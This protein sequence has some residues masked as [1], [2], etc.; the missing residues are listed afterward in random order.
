MYQLEI[1]HIHLP[2]PL[3]AFKT[4][5]LG[6]ANSLYQ[7]VAYYESNQID[8]PHHGF[9]NFLAA[10]NTFLP[11]HSDQALA[12]LEAEMRRQKQVL[13]CTLSY[14]LK[15]Q[16]EP[17]RSAHPDFIQFPV[18]HFFNP[19]VQIHFAAD[20]IIIN[21]PQDNCLKIYQA[22]LEYQESKTL[23]NRNLTIEQRISK[24][25]YIN[26]VNN[27]KQRIIEG[28]VYEINYCQEFY[29]SAP[30]FDPVSAFLGLNELSPMPFAGFY[31]VHDKYVMC[32]SPERFL[33]KSQNMLIA[34]PIKGTIR[35]GKTTPED[36]FLKNELATNE[37]EIAENMMIMDLVRN[38]LARCSVTGSVVVE[39]MFAIYSFK[40]VH[41]MITTIRSQVSNQTSLTEILKSTFPMG[42]MTG[43]PKIAAMRLIEQYEAFARGLY[44]GSLGYI[45]P[46]GDFDF[47]VVIRSMQYNAST[48][49]LSFAVGSAI[50][51]DSDPEQ[52][53]QECLLKAAA[54]L[55]VLQPKL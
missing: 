44:S 54:L 55:Q 11:I 34:Q 19:E 43:A 52:E 18:I 31:K 35:R 40:Q 21:S 22:I 1:L 53:Y 6:W 48:K 32:A 39:E 9:L 45:L 2:E 38:D 12:S 50:T 20:K 25:E 42:S 49:H 15:N 8:F 51:Y 26:Q 27:I 14:E 46:N 16:I 13:C 29:A 7:Q 23:N 37:K 5:A 41:Q 10:S 24:E 4:K 47:N 30:G 17:L 36:N 28:D 3:T 33:K